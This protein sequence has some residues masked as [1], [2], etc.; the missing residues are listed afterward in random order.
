MLGKAEGSGKRERPN[1]IW[2]GSVKEA[3]VCKVPAMLLNSGYFGNHSFLGSHGGDLWIAVYKKI[4]YPC[5]TAIC[6]STLSPDFLGSSEDLRNMHVITCSS[7]ISL[8]SQADV[9][10]EML[11]P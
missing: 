3:T 6:P 7:F 10:M 11:N 8:R 5:S 1:E 2:T 4:I 9:M